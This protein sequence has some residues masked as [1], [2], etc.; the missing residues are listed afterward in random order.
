MDLEQ[1]TDQERRE[2]FLREYQAAMAGDGEMPEWP[3]ED[4]ELQEMLVQLWAYAS[5]F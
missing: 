1:T 5:G 4:T 3:G 2:Q